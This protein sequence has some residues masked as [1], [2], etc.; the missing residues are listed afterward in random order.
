[1]TVTTKV[2]LAQSMD[3]VQK[4]IMSKCCFLL[5]FVVNMP[6]H[7]KYQKGQRRRQ[8]SLEVSRTY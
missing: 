7:F 8:Y 4:S 6:K 3:F 2:K 5:L 1:M